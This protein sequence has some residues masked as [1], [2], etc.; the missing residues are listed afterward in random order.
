MRRATAT[1]TG[2]MALLCLLAVPALAST[3]R[4][5]FEGSGTHVAFADDSGEPNRLDIV[6]PPQAGEIRFHD[7]ASPIEPRGKRCEEVPIGTF[8]VDCALDGQLYFE[9]ELDAGAGDD[10]ITSDVDERYRGFKVSFVHILGGAGDDRIDSGQAEDTIEPGPGE[11]AVHAGGG[12]D[13]MAAGA[14]DDGPDLYDAGSAGGTIS[15]A[16]REQRTRVRLDGI[17]NDGAAGEGDNVLRALGATGGSARDTFTGDEHR[18][19]LFGGHGPDRLG[20]ARTTTRSWAMPEP[21]GSTPDRATISCWTEA[22]PASTPST[23]VRGATS[24]RLIPA[25]SRPTARC[26]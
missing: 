6:V 11:D 2:T 15:Y 3:V 25:T 12:Y 22:H 20:A 19:Y 10:E 4:A 26:P 17:A 1:L 9:V 7:V 21:T 16:E 8:R 14:S 18:N 13:L 24:T 5:D 23:A